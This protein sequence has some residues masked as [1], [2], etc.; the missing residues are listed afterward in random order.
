MTRRDRSA[1]L[2]RAAEVYDAANREAAAII[3]ADR[4]RY[5]GLPV[6][7]AL[8]FLARIGMNAA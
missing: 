5:E 1:A 4:D 3:L 2:L 7:W 8:R 6:L